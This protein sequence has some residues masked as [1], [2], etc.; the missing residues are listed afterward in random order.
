LLSVT[1][2]EAD[3]QKRLVSSFRKMPA[4]RRLARRAEFPTRSLAA[5]RAPYLGRLGRSRRDAGSREPVESSLRVL[6]DFIGP[7]KIMWAIEDGAVILDLV[8]VP[9]A[10]Y[11]KQKP[12]A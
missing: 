5:E 11:P 8:L 12:A 6:A 7:H 3:D 9:P 1:G 10:A 4:H 2:S